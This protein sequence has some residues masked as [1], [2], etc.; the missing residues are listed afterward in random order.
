[1][2][3]ETVLPFVALRLATS[4][5]PRITASLGDL[6]ERRRRPSTT[7]SKERESPLAVK[8]SM[9]HLTSISQFC[10]EHAER[11]DGLEGGTI[12][13]VAASRQNTTYLRKGEHRLNPLLVVGEPDREGVECAYPELRALLQYTQK[14]HNT[15]VAPELFSSC[16]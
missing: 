15:V 10:D 9:K 6:I 4:H 14:E 16:S 2:A 7:C 5:L 11:R 12:S 3:L 8:Q 13:F 1:M